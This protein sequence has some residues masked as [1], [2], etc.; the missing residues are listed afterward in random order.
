[1]ALIPQL[2]V[3]MTLFGPLA[4][5]D[6]HT[7]L[8]DELVGLSG[9]QTGEM[10]DRGWYQ[11]DA[12]RIF[13]KP[14][15]F[16]A[17]AVAAS[18]QGCAELSEETTSPL[19]NLNLRESQKQCESQGG[20]ENVHLY[21]SIAHDIS[22]D[23]A[24][25][26]AAEDPWF[27]NKKLRSRVFLVKSE[28][29][30]EIRKVVLNLLQACKVVSYVYVSSHGSSGSIAWGKGGALGG[31]PLGYF[32]QRSFSPCMLAPGARVQ[33]DGCNLA[34]GQGAEQVRHQLD[35][36]LDTMAYRTADAKAP[37][38]DPFEG[39]EFYANTDLGYNFVPGKFGHFFGFRAHAWSGNDL[40][41]VFRRSSGIMVTDIP[42]D[43]VPACVD[44]TGRRGD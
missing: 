13:Q 15:L 4:S 17:Q 32:M 25:A 11:N 39:V 19:P 29:H 37:A 3:L 42:T 36:A 43:T 21:V 22:D 30:S 35:R 34:C 14:T 28:Q 24:A 10:R 33:F 23:M 16:P 8:V 12:P 41:V 40:G 18:S 1:M 20:Y 2:L 38:G 27:K 26:V 5:A 7:P 44:R 6:A 9:I 31:E